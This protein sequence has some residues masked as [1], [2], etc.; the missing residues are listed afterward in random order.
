MKLIIFLP[1]E[2]RGLSYTLLP[3]EG[4]GLRWG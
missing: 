3:L 2:D 4:G 1:L